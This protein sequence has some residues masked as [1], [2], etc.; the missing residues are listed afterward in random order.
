MANK[1]ADA[2]RAEIGCKARVVQDQGTGYR[3][4]FVPVENESKAREIAFRREFS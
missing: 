1:L 4:V 3:H 2:I